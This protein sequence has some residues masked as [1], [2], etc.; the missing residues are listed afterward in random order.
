MRHRED[1]FGNISEWRVE[2]QRKRKRKKKTGRK[3]RD[4]NKYEDEDGKE[5]ETIKNKIVVKIYGILSNDQTFSV[6]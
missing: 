3:E 4:E 6:I 2:E 5:G 1:Y